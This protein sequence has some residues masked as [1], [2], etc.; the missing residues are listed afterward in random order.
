MRSRGRAGPQQ[1]AA[2]GGEWLPVKSVELVCGLE[3]QRQ[4]CR[5]ALHATPRRLD[6]LFRSDDQESS[7]ASAREGDIRQPVLTT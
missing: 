7:K 2:G 5:G 1:G 6:V 4:G 3:G